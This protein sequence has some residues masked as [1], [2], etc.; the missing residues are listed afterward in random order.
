VNYPFLTQK[1]R[2]IETGLDYFL[3]RYYSSTQGRFTSPDA[4]FMDQSE[5]N[6]Q[7]WN[8]YS[9]VRNNPLKL[10]DPTGNSAEGECDRICQESREKA[11]EAR[12]P[13]E[14]EGIDTIVINS[15]QPTFVEVEL[16]SEPLTPLEQL[17]ERMTGDI[18]RD[19]W[20]FGEFVGIYDPTF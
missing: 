7:S 10:V 9:Y 17:D 18:G 6:P 15:K 16:V 1:G 3:A 12:K 14:A 5:G 19:V 2:D 11:A 20:T 13:A 4:P 8:L